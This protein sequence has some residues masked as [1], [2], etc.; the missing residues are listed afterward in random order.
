MPKVKV[1]F[2]IEGSVDIEVPNSTQT[3]FLVRGKFFKIDKSDLLLHLDTSNVTIEDFIPIEEKS[4]Q[5]GDEVYHRNLKRH[6]IIKSELSC[7][8]SSIIVEFNHPFQ[9]FEVSKNLLDKV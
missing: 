3:N 8:P 1:V 4:F 2:T 9:E 5:I 6:G 7:E